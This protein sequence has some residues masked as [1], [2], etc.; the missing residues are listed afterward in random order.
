VEGKHQALQL[1]PKEISD[2]I[3]ETKCDRGFRQISGGR[4]RKLDGLHRGSSRVGLDQ[5]TLA[6]SIRR[7]SAAIFYGATEEGVK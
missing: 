5:D 3:Y 2:A 1:V 7:Y 6:I 4:C